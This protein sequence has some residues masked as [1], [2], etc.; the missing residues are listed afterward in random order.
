MNP[1]NI[2]AQLTKKKVQDYT[3]TIIFFIIF[4]F[5][6]F[7]AIRPNLLT[8]FRLQKELEEL[9]TM[10]NEYEQVILNIV[11]N[12][13]V[14]EANRDNFYLLDEA[15]PQKV[16]AYK[17]VDDV[18]KSATD[19]G[20]ILQSINVEDI[21]IKTDQTQKS[22]L[23]TFAIEIETNSSQDKIKDFITALLNQRRLKTVHDLAIT[24]EDEA[25]TGKTGSQI[26][27]KVEGYYTL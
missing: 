20:I 10:D 27:M 2:T 22:K 19:S 6:V 21:N 13:S 26:I 16:E 9:K 1:K 14:L 23:N 5:F 12:Q 8:V 18:R 17:L 24:K 25:V 3:F 11:D 4:S 15:V 7:G